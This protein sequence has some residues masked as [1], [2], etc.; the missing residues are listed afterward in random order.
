MESEWCGVGILF[1]L[2]VFDLSTSMATATTG[3]YRAIVRRPDGCCC[4]SSA[5]LTLARFEEFHRH[6]RN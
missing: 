2:G 1:L 6:R 3:W 5:V 4:S